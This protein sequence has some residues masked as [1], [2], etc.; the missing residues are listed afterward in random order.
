MKCPLCGCEFEKPDERTCAGCG[1]MRHCNKHCC[2]N[3][4]YELVKET[5]LVRFIRRL[6]G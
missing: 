4:G 5:K 2:P 3:C 1:K 6:F